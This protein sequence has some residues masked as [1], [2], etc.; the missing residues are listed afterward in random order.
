MKPPKRAKNGTIVLKHS[1]SWNKFDNKKLFEALDKYGEDL[2]EIKKILPKRSFEE[3]FFHIKYYKNICKRAYIW[4]C[5]K[6]APYILTWIDTIKNVTSLALPFINIIDKVSFI[7]KIADNIAENYQIQTKQ[8]QTLSELIDF[9]NLYTFIAD[10][11]NSR[12]IGELKPYESQLLLSMIME[13]EAEASGHKY[14]CPQLLSRARTMKG[15]SNN[16]PKYFFIDP[17]EVMHEAY[18]IKKD[19]VIN[20][21]KD[22]QLPTN[23]D[24]SMILSEQDISSALIKI[25]NQ[26]DQPYNNDNSNVA[27]DIEDESLNSMDFD[28]PCTSLMPYKHYQNRVLSAKSKETIDSDIQKSLPITDIY[29]SPIIEDNPLDLNQLPYLNSLAQFSELFL[30]NRSYQPKRRTI[31]HNDGIK[32]DLDKLIDLLYFLNPFCLPT[33]QITSVKDEKNDVIKKFGRINSSREIALPLSSNS[34]ATSILQINSDTSVTLR[35]LKFNSAPIQASDNC[36]DLPIN[37]LP[38][39]FDLQTLPSKRI[40]ILGIIKKLNTSDGKTDNMMID[41]IG[42][43]NTVETHTL[44]NL[45]NLQFRDYGCYSKKQ[46]KI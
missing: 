26:T 39:T 10:I 14:L 20:T 37:N 38:K 13:I 1:R 24:I 19:R 35:N 32:F 4:Q 29:S 11:F 9:K 5:K 17:L 3:I 30:R 42:S 40:K 25:H 41:F 27:L 7:G 2:K 45:S 34:V 36:K 28:A 15:L 31:K 18:R 6:E 33:L 12:K 21:E 8:L 46:K 43:N 23:P 44:K 22:I 16:Y